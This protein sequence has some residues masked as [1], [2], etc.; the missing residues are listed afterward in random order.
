MLSD[1][2]SQIWQ[3]Y[4]SKTRVNFRLWFSLQYW[5]IN[6]IRFIQS[7]LTTIYSKS[8][9]QCSQICPVKSDNFGG[10]IVVRFIQSNLTSF[11]FQ[12]KGNW[13]SQIC[14][15]KS[16]N[17]VKYN[18]CQIYPVKSAIFFVQKGVTIFGFSLQFW[19]ITILYS[20]Q[21]YPVKSDTNSFQFK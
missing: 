15:V 3:V 4:C 12:N 13:C 6:A 14:P 8:S 1:L 2:S 10:I 11:S 9:I 17:F 5:R 7:N 19:G 21:I 16:D 18:C 20:N